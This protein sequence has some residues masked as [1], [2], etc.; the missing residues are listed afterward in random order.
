MLPSGS[1]V[2]DLPETIIQEAP[3]PAAPAGANRRNLLFSLAPLGLVL[4]F[5]LFSL[6]QR[7]AKALAGET[8]FGRLSETQVRRLADDL[9]AQLTDGAPAR[10]GDTF[11]HEVVSQRRNT[12]LREWEVI[13]GEADA[14][15]QYVFRF[16]AET[17]GVYAV[18]RRWPDDAAARSNAASESPDGLSRT[19]AET[20]ARR[21]LALLGVR[22]VR[23]LA[24]L[25]PPV[26]SPSAESGD[27]AWHFVYRRPTAVLSSPGASGIAPL[28]LLRVTVD[29]YNGSLLSA[30]NAA[31]AR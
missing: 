11:R 22:S 10:P 23:D 8:I 28:L 15:S 31:N 13:C 14:G 1:V 2:R 20:Q 9:C 29:A 17:R 12:A 18:N 30:W 3:C 27:F 25:R 5:C 7:G 24:L 4:A 6:A 21:Y 26:R 19:Q 16:N